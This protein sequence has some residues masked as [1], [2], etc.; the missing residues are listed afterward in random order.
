[1]E[2]RSR[3]RMLVDPISAPDG[4]IGVAS[5]VVSSV[6]TSYLEYMVSTYYE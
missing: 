2:A 6:S 5:R 3:C 4:V 1:M